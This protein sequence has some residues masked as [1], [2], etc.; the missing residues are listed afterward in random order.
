[1]FSK[2]SGV[3]L[4]SVAL[5][6]IPFSSAVL[7]TVSLF[8]LNCEFFGLSGR[9]R[10]LAVLF[11]GMSFYYTLFQ[12][13]FTRETFAFP[14]VLLAIWIFARITKSQHQACA[15]I[16][17]ILI[18]AIIFS[19]QMSSYLFFIVSIIMIAGFNIFHRNGKLNHFLFLTATMLGAYT[20]FVVLSFSVT[21]WTYAFEGI[22]AIL[23]REGPIAIMRPYPIFQKYLSI[24]QYAI[25]GILATI[26]GFKLLRERN[27]DWTVLTL[28]GFFLLAFIVSTI[29]RLS[30]PAD[31]WSYTYY[32]SLRGTIWAFIGISVTVAIGIAYILELKNVNKI[33]K[34]D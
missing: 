4:M 24:S 11:F 8:L 31:P 19:H 32:M 15:I 16:A 18:G 1:M 14:L 30:T 2:V 3:P 28:I 23:H 22:Q 20:M 12:S 7:T 10:N 6:I 17:S 26:G 25:L 29:L 34:N 21:Q 9:A 13:Q 5:F 33:K 27:R